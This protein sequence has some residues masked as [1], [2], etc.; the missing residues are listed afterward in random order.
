MKKPS[1]VK[2]QKTINEIAIKCKDKAFVDQLIGR[3]FDDTKNALENIIRMCESVAKMHTAYM[4]QVISSHDIDY[5]CMSVGL[6]K[7]KSQYRKYICIGNNAEKFRDHIERMPL[8][9]SVLYELTTLNS[10]TFE[11]L[12]NSG[13]IHPEL[14]LSEVKILA[15]KPKRTSTQTKTKNIRPVQTVSISF[16]Y[17]KLSAETRVFIAN[18]ICRIRKENELEISSPILSQLESVSQKQ[19][20]EATLEIVA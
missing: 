1:K 17:E 6:Q 4:D 15:N 7:N 19:L 5:F 14:T 2:P 9:I 18:L 10:D 3:Y 12:I 16:D 13:K 20:E 11:L 8:A